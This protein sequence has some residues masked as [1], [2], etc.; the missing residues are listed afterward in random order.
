MVEVREW[1]NTAAR[2]TRSRPKAIIFSAMKFPRKLMDGF[3]FATGARLARPVEV[4]VDCG[5]RCAVGPDRVEVK[6]LR[7]QRRCDSRILLQ[8]RRLN[9]FGSRAVGTLRAIILVQLRKL[10]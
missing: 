9:D 8:K 10:D 5:K 6:K 4:K 2:A 1:L 3:G 7:F